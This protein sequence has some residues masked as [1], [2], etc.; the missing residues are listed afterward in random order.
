MTL[1][2]KSKNSAPICYTCQ[3]KEWRNSQA[4]LDIYW[5]E[6]KIFSWINKILSCLAN[7]NSMGSVRKKKRNFFVCQIDIYWI[8]GYFQLTLN[9]K[10]KSINVWWPDV[11]KSEFLMRSSFLS[12][13]SANEDSLYSCVIN[14]VMLWHDQSSYD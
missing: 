12:V 8:K 2:L 10:N 11:G 6:F 1:F 14:V 5:D 3:Q 13:T 4:T 7:S 9:Q